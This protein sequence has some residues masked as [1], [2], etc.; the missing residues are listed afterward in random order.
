M[1]HLPDAR[2]LNPLVVSALL[3]AALCAAAGL[4]VPPPEDL[5]TATLVERLVHNPFVLV[6]AF[7]GTWAFLYGLIQ[8]WATGS[9]RKGGLAGWLSG[10][11]RERQLTKATDTVLAVDLFADQWDFL[12]ARRMA[13]LSYAVWVLPLLGFIGTVIGISD[14]IGGLGTVFADGDRQQALESVLGALRFAFDTTFAGL[15]LVIPVMALSTWI[16]LASDDA[17]DRAMRARFGASAT[18]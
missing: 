2:L 15:V 9:T 13:P 5:A 10:Q 1:T 11:G 17:R 3:A 12:A 16:E 4:A 18:A 6:I 7:V 8:L 14:A